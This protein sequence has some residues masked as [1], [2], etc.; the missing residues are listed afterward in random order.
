[1]ALSETF[2]GS[3]KEKFM[4]SG[5]YD[6][7]FL[8]LFKS[9]LSEEDF[10]NLQNIAKTWIAEDSAADH[11]R[12]EKRFKELSKLHQET[13]ESW[14]NHKAEWDKIAAGLREENAEL[15]AEIARLKADGIYEKRNRP[16][17]GWHE[18]QSPSGI[19][20]KASGQAPLDL[21][22]SYIDGFGFNC[23]GDIA[24]WLKGKVI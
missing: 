22:K 14:W 19:R 11:E 8:D 20:R 21:Y 6:F 10:K 5:K 16:C 18:F 2:L 24:S 17:M 7:D 3:F 15:R 1:M 9:I 12:L 13:V 23:L 4:G